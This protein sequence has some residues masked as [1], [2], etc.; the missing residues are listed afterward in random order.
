NAWISTSE[1][2]VQTYDDGNKIYKPDYT[3]TPQKL[4]LNL[5]KAGSSESLLGENVTNVK[6]FKI[7]GSETTEIISKDSTDSIFISGTSNSILTTSVN[8]STESSITIWMVEGE[9][10][11]KSSNQNIPFIATVDLSILYLSKATI[12]PNIYAPDG[13]FFRNGTPS[14][15]RIN[16]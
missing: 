3:V 11:D 1:Q 10:K 4:T 5:T 13:D 15:I 16:V 12:I 8:T 14:R 2:P 7:E 9:W 6:W